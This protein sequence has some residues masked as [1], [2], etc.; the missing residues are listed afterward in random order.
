M[1]K[2]LRI[3][4]A[5]KLLKAREFSSVELTRACLAR[6]QEV[7]PKLQALVT[8]TEDLALSQARAADA[9]IAA[10]EAGALTGIPVVIKDNICTKGV[11]TTCSSK[12]LGNFVPPYNATVVDRLF[13]AHR[14]ARTAAK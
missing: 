5:S 8:V 4:E 12:M 6:I 13:N 14:P 7:E 10:G 3:W 2:Q 9:L 11:R 1:I